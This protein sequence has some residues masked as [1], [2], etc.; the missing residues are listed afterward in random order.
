L[1]KE[2][3]M[4]Q[5]SC[6]RRKRYG[7]SL[8]I[9]LIFLCINIPSQAQ[10]KTFFP[11]DVFVPV[12]PTPVKGNGKTHLV[13]ELHLTNFLPSD[14]MLTQVEVF[15]D[16]KAETLLSVTKDKA[17]EESI[18]RPGVSGELEDKRIIGG[19]L[20]AV[21][22][23]WLTFEEKKDVPSQ[24]F[25]RLSVS[26]GASGKEKRALALDIEPVTVLSD[27][28]P[29]FGPPVRGGDWFVASATSHT[30]GHRRAL[31][32]FDGR[33]RISQR[34]AF[35]LMKFGEDGKLSHGDPSKNENFYGHGED[36]LAVADGIVSHIQDGVTANIPPEVQKPGTMTRENV[37]GNLV[38]LDIGKG[39]YVVYAHVKPGSIRV[40]VGE[41]VSRGQMLAGLG[42]TG[43]ST[44]PHLHFQLVDRNML[45]AAEGLPYVF[46]SFE[47]L[48]IF[49]KSG[50][51]M[52]AYFM[53]G[54][55]WK[56][57]HDQKPEKRLEEIPMGNQVVR[58]SKK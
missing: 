24:L 51:E 3:K 34:Y 55:S 44:A 39:L 27:P 14:L 2:V 12:A 29:A 7:V 43:N 37:G 38:I 10:K 23:M 11:Y 36:L 4:N 54:N 40:K 47:V 8:G 48:R 57:G 49:D 45:I 6:L 22:Y 25:H 31:M 16:K 1:A 56:S 21:I 32:A 41:S 15:R 5:N 50:E 18:N 17:L 9:A 28:L 13:Y 33:A 26:F 58:F 30:T 52:E 20:R 19:G 35:D 53:E 46:E 42:N